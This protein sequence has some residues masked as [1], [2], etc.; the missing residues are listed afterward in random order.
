MA[1]GVQQLFE[2]RLQHL[3][4]LRGR[5]ELVLRRLQPQLCVRDQSCVHHRRRLHG[6]HR[7]RPGTQSLQV[8]G[9]GPWLSS[10]LHHRHRVRSVAVVHEQGTL[11]GS[12][13]RRVSYVLVLPRGR[14]R[15]TEGMLFQRRMPRGQLRQRRVPGHSWQVRNRVRLVRCAL[16]TTRCAWSTAS[17]TPPSRRRP[18]P[19]R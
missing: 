17:S 15:R 16:T 2:R 1:R 6:R 19:S 5:S 11:R 12:H 9:G 13:V 4:R 14:L 7:L 18:R 8:R 3:R 10:G